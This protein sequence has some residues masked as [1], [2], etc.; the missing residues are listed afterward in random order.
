MFLLSLENIMKSLE[1]IV[2]IPIKNIIHD[3]PMKC[4]SEENAHDILSSVR[5]KRLPPCKDT[6]GKLNPTKILSIQMAYDNGHQ[7]ELPP[8]KVKQYKSSGYYEVIDGRHRAV[9]AM[10]FKEKCISANVVDANVV[11]TN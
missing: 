10:K 1:D 2:M 4:W 3:T 8:I 9:M 7:N 6:V 5:P 11:D